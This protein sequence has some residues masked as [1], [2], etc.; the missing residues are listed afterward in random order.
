MTAALLALWVALVLRSVA[1]TS[2]LPAHICRLSS[3]APPLKATMKTDTTAGVAA[4]VSSTKA[5]RF[6][7]S[8]VVV[9]AAVKLVTALARL[10]SVALASAVKAVLK[11]TVTTAGEVPALMA[12][13]Q[14]A[15][16]ELAA[17]VVVKTQPRVLAGVAV[18]LLVEKGDSAAV[19]VVA[20][21]NLEAGEAVE[22]AIRAAMEVRV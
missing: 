8:R 19:V 11:R 12:R 20:A 18:R 9:V 3:G 21:T 13:A 5:L 6:C 10:E 15:L 22:A 16:M 7:L 14:T 17:A 2:S 4:G 1:T